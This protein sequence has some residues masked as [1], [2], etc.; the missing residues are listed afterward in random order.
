MTELIEKALQLLAAACAPEAMAVL[1]A[2]P[3]E[4]KETASLLERYAIPRSRGAKLLALVTLLELARKR[5]DGLTLADERLTGRI[6]DGDYFQS[7]YVQLAVQFEEME[8]VRYL[9]P[10]LKRHYVRLALGEAGGER[11]VVSLEGYLRAEQAVSREEHA[12]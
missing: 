12:I 11:L 9:A 3:S 10:L 2:D 6:L 4:L 7:L 1:D 5:H 8:L